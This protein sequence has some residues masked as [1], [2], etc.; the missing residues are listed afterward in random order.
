MTFEHFPVDP[1][2][3]KTIPEE[4]E[5]PRG[6]NTCAASAREKGVDREIKRVAGRSRKRVQ[7]S[8]TVATLDAS[9]RA[10]LRV[11]YK[12]LSKIW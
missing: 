11:K 5:H 4:H 8:N 7:P 6:V 3:F 10:E 9:A 2:T 1:T 12:F